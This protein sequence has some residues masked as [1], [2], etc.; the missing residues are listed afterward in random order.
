MARPRC[1]CLLAGRCGC[2]WFDQSDGRR[3]TCG[4]RLLSLYPTPN[5]AFED[6]KLLWVYHPPI[7]ALPEQDL[8]F[9]QTVVGS[10]VWMGSLKWLLRLLQRLENE[11]E[12]TFDDAD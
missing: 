8:T 3:K 9:W 5:L 4:S 12:Y 6:A 1:P 10:N 11:R 7:Y 2:Q